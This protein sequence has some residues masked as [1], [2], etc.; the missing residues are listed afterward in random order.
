ML[1]TDSTMLSTRISSSGVT[2]LQFT[3]KALD[4]KP[5]FINVLMLILFEDTTVH[6]T[7]GFMGLGRSEVM[8]M[9]PVHIDDGSLNH[10][11][12]SSST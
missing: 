9:G 6:L 7:T 1:A 3:Q 11:R 5:A 4:V 8:V 2:F 12:C 10:T